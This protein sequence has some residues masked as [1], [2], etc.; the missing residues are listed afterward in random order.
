[1]KTPQEML[2]KFEQAA[3]GLNYGIVT[4]TLSIK[5]KGKRLYEICRKE[6]QIYNEELS[7]C[8]DLRT[9]EEAG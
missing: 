5:G 6:S 1:M 2:T 8:N 7:T 3:V 4:L 9:K